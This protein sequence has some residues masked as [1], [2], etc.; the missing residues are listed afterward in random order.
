MD[1]KKKEHS[2]RNAITI[3]AI[4]VMRIDHLANSKNHTRHFASQ[5]KNLYFDNFPG[6]F[7]NYYILKRI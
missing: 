1:I 5:D 2:F 7:Y 6:S 4:P 3:P